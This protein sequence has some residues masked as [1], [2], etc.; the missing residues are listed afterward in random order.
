MN[1]DAVTKP[2]R[3]VWAFAFKESRNKSHE[4]I[5]KEMRRNLKLASKFR[6]IEL[7]N[8]RSECFCTATRTK[9]KNISEADV[10]KGL[11]VSPI[12]RGCDQREQS[13]SGMTKRINTP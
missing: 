10:L 1:P 6:R 12:R 9:S 7:T 4:V 11:W 3:T 5:V 8:E 13:L 2:T